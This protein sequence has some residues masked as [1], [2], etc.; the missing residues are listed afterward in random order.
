MKDLDHSDTS[1][2]GHIY[3]ASPDGKPGELFLELHLEE[4]EEQDIMRFRTPGSNGQEVMLV[5]K[6]EES[7]GANTSYRGMRGGEEVWRFLIEQGWKN[8]DYS[9][10]RFPGLVKVKN[11]EGKY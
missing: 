4:G 11:L 8:T 3:T 10:F 7:P 5:I 1:R 9:T 2:T 6:D